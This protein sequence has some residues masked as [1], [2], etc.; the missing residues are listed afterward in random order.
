MINNINSTL[1]LR[2]LATIVAVSILTLTLISALS[3]TLL[4]FNYQPTTGGT[5]KSLEM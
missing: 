5:Y 4:A 2:R 1:S 3:G